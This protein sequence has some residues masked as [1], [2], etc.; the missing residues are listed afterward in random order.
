LHEIIFDENTG[1][2]RAL[3]TLNNL[4]QT[5]CSEQL[6]IW[7]VK[8]ILGA[9]SNVLIWIVKNLQPKK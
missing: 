1:V 4:L 7:N 8:R 3:A 2:Q 5:T 9:H 6:Y